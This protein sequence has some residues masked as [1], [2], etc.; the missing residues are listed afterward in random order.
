MQRIITKKTFIKIFENKEFRQKLDKIILNFFGLEA[1][2][3]IKREDKKLNKNVLEF[4]LFI[5]TELTLKI[6]VLDDKNLFTTSKTFY[7]NISFREVSKYHALLIPCYWEIYSPYS[8]A[9]QKTNPKLILIAALFSCTKKEEIQKILQKL[10]EFTEEEITT[11]L[12]IIENK[13]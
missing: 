3:I 6:R 9:H 7:I 8:Y 2:T 11:I 5:N 4:V 12:E 1:N 13:K 10:E